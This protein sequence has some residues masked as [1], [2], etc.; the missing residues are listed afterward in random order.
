MK[1]P[2]LSA[3]DIALTAGCC[4]T[5]IAIGLWYWVLILTAVYRKCRRMGVNTTLWM[6]AAL[7]FNLAALAAL[8]LYAA[9]RGTCANC[10]RVRSS[11][12]KFCDRCGN[13]LK[14]NVR[15]AGSRQIYY[16]PIAATVV[17]NGR[18]QIDENKFRI[19]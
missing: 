19:T 2:Y 16:P 3:G 8:Y 12:G 17:K 14:K 5:A 15:S 4:V 11:S 9:L 7:V 6:P 18:K 10:G 1:R 13:M